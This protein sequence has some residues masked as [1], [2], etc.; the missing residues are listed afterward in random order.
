LNKSRFGFIGL[1]NM[2][3]PMAKSLLKNGF[4]VV[5]F[6]RK[7]EAKAEIS[8]LGASLAAS[9]RQVAASCPVVISV[10]LD[11]NQTDQI[12]FGPEGLW[13]GFSEG[14]TL[15]ISSTLSPQ[16]CRQLYA[17]AS[18]R[19]IQVID[20]P[21][22][23]PSGQKHILGGLTIMV[24]GDENAVKQ[25][26]PIFLAMGSNVFYLGKIGNGQICKLVAQIN[27]FD[28]GTVTRESLNIGVKAGLDLKIM[29]EALSLGL[30]STRGLQNL[31][32]TLKAAAAN[33][34]T[35]R[36]AGTMRTRDRVL[37]LDLAKEVGVAVPI[38]DCIR[39]LPAE[40]LYAAYDAAMRQY[41]SK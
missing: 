37:A 25:N 19:K 29:V 3:M 16:Y 35:P 23:D 24:G 30:G 15:I 10:V 40:G 21:V 11:E 18:A 17:K 8:A 14:S 13:D 34:Q 12:L 38:A 22:S 1:G 6:A 26:W 5:V 32:E 39:N 4:P 20:A 33:H 27:A 36:P 41:L 2:G 31:A 9:A 28:I 7:P